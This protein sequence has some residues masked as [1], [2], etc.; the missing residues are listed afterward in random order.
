MQQ[1]QEGL[2]SERVRLAHASLTS[3]DT[4]FDDDGV[5]LMRALRKRTQHDAFS[6]TPSIII[7]R[8]QLLSYDTSGPPS[9]ASSSSPA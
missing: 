9:S 7:A 5:L 4:D 8:C 6:V 2:T 3:S 1:Q